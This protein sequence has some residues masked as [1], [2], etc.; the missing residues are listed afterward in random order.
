MTNHSINYH[1][2]ALCAQLL[3]TAYSLGRTDLA[4]NA[5]ILVVSFGILRVE[6]NGLVVITGSSTTVVVESGDVSL[7]DKR[8]SILLVCLKGVLHVLCC[9]DS[10]LDVEESPSHGN[11]NVFVL[12][13]LLVNGL[14][15]VFQVGRLALDYFRYC[16]DSGFVIV[17]SHCRH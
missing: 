9:V 3:K 12:L 13:V 17:L 15:L 8:R 11:K 1:I 10:I 2:G 6:I 14:Y 7:E 4:V 16:I 5:G